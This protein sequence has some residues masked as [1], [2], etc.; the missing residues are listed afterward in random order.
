MIRAFAVTW[1]SGDR[2]R[3]GQTMVLREKVVEKYG[4][5]LSI[6]ILINCIQIFKSTYKFKFM[7][8]SSDCLRTSGGGVYMCTCLCICVQV[9]LGMCMCISACV[10]MCACV[11]L[12][13]C[14]HVHVLEVG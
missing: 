1:V 7:Y 2:Q 6:Y 3:H 10:S 11:Y 8:I 13:V 5:F 9:C 12:H 4:A 14:V